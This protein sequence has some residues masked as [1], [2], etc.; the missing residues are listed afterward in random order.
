MSFLFDMTVRMPEPLYPDPFFCH[1]NTF[2]LGEEW[3]A[4][5]TRRPAE[6]TRR[7]AT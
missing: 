2:G 3:L 7:A 6:L 5:D 1:Q 4:G